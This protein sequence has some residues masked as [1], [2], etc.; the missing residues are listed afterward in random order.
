MPFVDRDSEQFCLS[1]AEAEVERRSTQRAVTWTPVYAS[2]T[3]SMTANCTCSCS[4]H[5][6]RS[7]QVFDDLI[8]RRSTLRAI[9][10]GESPRRMIRQQHSPFPISIRYFGC[11]TRKSGFTQRWN[12]PQRNRARP[13]TNTSVSRIPA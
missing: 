4:R 5:Q 9:V 7:K 11:S 13:V 3:K 12:G 6:S 10:V 2:S 8:R 1:P